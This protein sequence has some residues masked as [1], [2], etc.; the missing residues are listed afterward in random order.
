MG[1]ALLLSIYLGTNV[2]RLFNMIVYI[3]LYLPVCEAM[4]LALNPIFCPLS[5]EYKDTNIFR[6]VL[7]T[8]GKSCPQ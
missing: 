5:L 2:E 4:Y 3:L 8:S 7:F 1:S 6:P